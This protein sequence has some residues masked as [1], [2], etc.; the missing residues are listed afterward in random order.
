MATYGLKNDRIIKDY[1]ILAAAYQVNPDVKQAL[2]IFFD[3][4]KI[5][6]N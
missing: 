5:S 3:L 4:K 1:V 2:S 6:I